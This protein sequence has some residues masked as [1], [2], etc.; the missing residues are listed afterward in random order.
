VSAIPGTVTRRRALTA[1]AALLLCACTARDALRGRPGT[2]L[3]RVRPGA[4]RAEVEQ[5]LG[6][7]KREWVTRSGV[8]Y[9]QYAVDPGSPGN[10]GMAALNAGIFVATVGLYEALISADVVPPPTLKT[11]ME[12]LA[13]SY[14]S[15]EVVL[16]VF[17]AITEFT[18]LPDDGIPRA[19]APSSIAP[20]NSGLTAP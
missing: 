18:E 3:A 5:V 1:L 4:T 16:G 13:I 20:G 11:P 14:D 8:R 6:E 15:A 12:D 2:D 10:V 7:P 17:S 9:G 19:V